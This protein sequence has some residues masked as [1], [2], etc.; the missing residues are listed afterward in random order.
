MFENFVFVEIELL[1]L[2]V[3]VNVILKDF[4]S[5]NKEVECVKIKFEEL[6]RERI[7]YGV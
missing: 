2:I 1:R 5:F 7:N 4:Y 6:K 3:K